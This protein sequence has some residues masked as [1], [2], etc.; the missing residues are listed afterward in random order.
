MVS[1]VSLISFAV[2]NSP[3]TAPDATGS[4]S[5]PSI[6][7]KQVETTAGYL[8]NKLLNLEEG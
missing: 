2:A 7:Q 3:S 1:C 8:Y 6:R 5:I 4:G